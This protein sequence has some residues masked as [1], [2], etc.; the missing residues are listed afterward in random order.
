MIDDLIN[1]MSKKFYPNENVSG[2]N[3]IAEKDELIKIPKYNSSGLKNYQII[4]NP[5][6]KDMYDIKGWVIIDEVE[7]IIKWIYN[8]DNFIKGNYKAADYI[9]SSIGFDIR[10]FEIKDK[11]DEIK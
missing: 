4:K 10:D 1:E 3:N 11:S 9:F 8:I 6:R 7:Y 5:S 2:I